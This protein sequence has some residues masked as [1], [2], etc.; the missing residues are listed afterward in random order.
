MAQTTRPLKKKLHILAVDDETELV[1]LIEDLLEA[2][3]RKIVVARDGR[4]AL[5]LAA[6]EKFDLVITDHRMPRSGGLELVRKLRQRKY[7]GKVVVLSG[8]LPEDHIGTYEDLG[9]DE[10]VGK[11][12]DSEELR[13]IVEDLEE[14]I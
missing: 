10:I 11:P 12:F 5:A 1:G 3:H 4:E 8:F 7:E 9:V 6:K 13:G 14:E 2:P